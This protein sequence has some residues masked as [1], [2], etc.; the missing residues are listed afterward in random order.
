VTAIH[1]GIVLFIFY[2]PTLSYPLSP[3]VLWD[4]LIHSSRRPTAPRDRGPPLPR[5]HERAVLASKAVFD[6][7]KSVTHAP[8]VLTP[9]FDFLSLFASRADEKTLSLGSRLIQIFLVSPESCPS[10][11]ELQFGSC[12]LH[13]RILI[14]SAVAEPPGACARG[15]GG[16]RSEVTRIRAHV[17]GRN[18]WGRSPPPPHCACGGGRGGAPPRPRQRPRRCS[19]VAGQRR[20]VGPGIV[21]TIL[22]A[23]RMF[24]KMPTRERVV[25]SPCARCKG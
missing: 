19:S 20:H 7:S 15:G 2:L 24:D 11:R 25:R 5:C 1:G 13:H 3:M 14:S 4:G 17:C 6:L 8:Q 10:C 18:G 12:H 23:H 22:T 16:S 9:V 21:F